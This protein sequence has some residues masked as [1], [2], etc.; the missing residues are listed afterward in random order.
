[1]KTFKIKIIKTKT[2]VLKNYSADIVTKKHNSKVKVLTKSS[3]WFAD[4]GD[5]RWSSFTSMTDHCPVPR[6]QGAV[7]R[8]TEI[9]KKER[10]KNVRKKKS[11]LK[12]KNQGEKSKAQ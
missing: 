2:K 11:D 8:M 3:C 7:V 5:G 1:M 12:K 4:K 9:E 10:Q 6:W